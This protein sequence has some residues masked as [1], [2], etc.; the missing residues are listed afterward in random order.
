VRQGD[1][2]VIAEQAPFVMSRLPPGVREVEVIRRD[3]GRPNQRPHQAGDI[4][5]DDDSISRTIALNEM[6]Q[7]KHPTL[8]EFDAEEIPFRIVTGHGEEERPFARADLDLDWVGVAE[9][10][11]P[12]GR[13]SGKVG[14][15]DTHQQPTQKVQ[16]AR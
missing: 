3:R 10:L 8:R 15:R 2:E 6:G 5:V 7:T 9:N 12:G 16:G 13:R 11:C 14:G 4:G 1:G